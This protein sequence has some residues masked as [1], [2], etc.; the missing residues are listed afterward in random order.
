M[1]P[2]I[3][4]QNTECKVKQ[5]KSRNSYSRNMQSEKHVKGLLNCVQFEAY[6]ANKCI[7]TLSC[8]QPFSKLRTENE[9][10][11]ARLLKPTLVCQ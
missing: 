5:Q 1:K 6:T 9:A 3:L 7:K 11:S 8:N 2:L 10:C 4:R